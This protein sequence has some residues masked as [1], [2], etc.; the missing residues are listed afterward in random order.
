[1]GKHFFITTKLLV[2][3]SLREI[4]HGLL[5]GQT[6]N[7]KSS[8]GPN[9]KMGKLEMAYTLNPIPL[10]LSKDVKDSENSDR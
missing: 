6:K 8:R 1:M 2:Q 4:S 9:L 7:S 10:L 3:K 5:K